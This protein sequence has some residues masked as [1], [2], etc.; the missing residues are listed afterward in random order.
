M[1]HVMFTAFEGQRGRKVAQPLPMPSHLL[2]SE[3]GI[4]YICPGLASAP[5][6]KMMNLPL[7]DFGIIVTSVFNGIT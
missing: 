2:S 3:N 5:P 1:Y 6:F 7:A 4:F